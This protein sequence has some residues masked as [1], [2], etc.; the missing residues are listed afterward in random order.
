M[1]IKAVLTLKDFKASVHWVWQMLFV[2]HLWGVRKIKLQHVNQT[3]AL[4][5]SDSER[6]VELDVRNPI[7]CWKLLKV[8]VPLA[9][10]WV[11][12][13]LCDG[14]GWSGGKTVN[15]GQSLI[16]TSDTQVHPGEVA[17]RSCLHLVGGEMVLWEA[18][19][20]SHH[21]VVLV[22]AP[23]AVH[24]IVDAAGDVLDVLHVGPDEEIP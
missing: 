3:F 13:H 5:V 10:F 11:S 6:V 7:S 19:C 4:V 20:M 18:V 24:F 15:K 12:V 21:R 14:D 23:H 8:K 9:G 22:E 17:C 16:K 1:M 2:W